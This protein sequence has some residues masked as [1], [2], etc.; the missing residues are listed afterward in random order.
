MDT[1]QRLA[2]ALRA[3]ASGGP[4]AGSVPV[5]P[6]PTA[7]PGGQRRQVLVALVGALAVGVLLGMAL[8]VVSVLVPGLLPPLG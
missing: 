5:R 4:W 6:A 3:E 8:A 2:D 1:E 7:R